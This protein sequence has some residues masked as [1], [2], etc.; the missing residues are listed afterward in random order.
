V[1]DFE[2][3]LRLTA[4]GR[5]VVTT[6]REVSRELDRYGDTA[7]RTGRQAEQAG[8]RS[9]RMGDGLSRAGRDARVARGELGGLTRELGRLQTLAGGIAGI[10]LVAGLGTG[11]RATT[12]EALSYGQALAEV[13]TLIEGTREEM[14]LLERATREQAAAFGSTPTAQANALYQIISAGASDAREAILLLEAANRLAI[15]GVTDVRTAADGLTTIL[16]AYGREADAA[17]DISDVLF[18]AMRAGKTTI[19]ELATEFGT[20][21]SLAAQTEVELEELLAAVAALTLGGIDTNIAMTGLRQVLASVVKPSSEAR[22]EAERLGIEFTTAAL[23]TQGLAGFIEQLVEATGGSEASLSLL[24]GGVEALVPILALAGAQGDDFARILDDMSGRAGATEDAFDKMTEALAVRQTKAIA[25]IREEFLDLAGVLN[26]QFVEGLEATAENLDALTAAG[27]VA[28]ALLAGRFTASLSI[29]ALTAF[30][31][32]NR[33]AVAGVV[34]LGRVAP[35]TAAGLVSLGTAA[36]VARG[37]LALLGGPVGIAASAALG[38]YLFRD[39]IFEAIHATDDQASSLGDLND[40]IERAR[41]LSAEAAEASLRQAYASTAAAIARRE[42]AR[43]ELQLARSRA[44]AERR[45]AGPGGFLGTTAAGVSAGTEAAALEG[46]LAQLDRTLA[47]NAREIEHLQLR[48]LQLAAGTE[49]AAERTEKLGATQGEAADDAEEFARRLA[50]VVG[51]LD[52]AAARAAEYTESVLVLA[53]AHQRG[54]ISGERLADL[55]ARLNAEIYPTAESFLAAVN[56]ELEE[57]ARLLDLSTRERE[58]ELEVRRR[59]LEAQAAGIALSDREIAQLRA[60]IRSTRDAEA[61]AERRAEVERRAADEV[62]DIW[63]QA[64]RRVQET[65]ADAIVDALDGQLDDVEDIADRFVDIWKRAYAEA[66]A[67]RVFDGGE[68]GVAGLSA[69][70][71]QRGPG[72]TPSVELAGIGS[73]DTALGGLTR[74]LDN[75]GTNLGFAAPQPQVGPPVA[76]PGTTLTQGIGTGFQALGAGAVGFSVGQSIGDLLGLGTRGANTLGGAAG[77]AAAGA[78]IGSVVPGIGTAIGAVVGGILGGLGGILGG[79]GGQNPFVEADVTGTGGAVRKYDG[80]DHT[81][82]IRL[83]DAVNESLSAIADAFGTGISARN[84]G[85]I[86]NSEAGVSFRR[87]GVPHD[88]R[89]LFASPEAA[90]VAAIQEGVRSGVVTG[91]DENARTALT[92]SRAATPEA[93][94]ADLEFVSTYNSLLEAGR[95]TSRFSAEL[96][97]LNST[98]A[99]AISR[100]RELGLET[101]A[102]GDARERALGRVRS[103]FEEETRLAILDLTDPVRAALERQQQEARQFLLDAAA[104]GADLDL[105]RRR[106]RLDREALIAE[107][108]AGTERMAAAFRDDIQTILD[109]LRFGPASGL[110]EQ[111]RLPVLLERFQ[112]VAARARFDETA[113]ADLDQVTRE[114]LDVAGSV[115]ASSADFFAIQRQVESQLEALAAAGLDASGVQ[116]IADQVG[117]IELDPEFQRLLDEIGSE[118][119]SGNAEVVDLLTQ[120]R[121]AQIT[122]API[123]Q[124][125]QPGSFPTFDPRQLRL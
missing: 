10:S 7:E 26:E 107:L 33:S 42:E 105:A 123:S 65:F 73:L 56:A 1:T 46:E 5:A 30:V 60:W 45:R 98:F 4:D 31:A 71:G 68:G 49:K 70:F 3:G 34:L 95:E 21:G 78:T 41:D 24:F 44:A 85:V 89:T 9:Q 92:N 48:L 96:R 8:R 29:G 117:Q 39:S 101:D 38:I 91:L 32:A 102:L 125:G 28:A 94:I 59:V 51:Q 93:L 75:F 27:T 54:A 67:A 113:R 55:V 15:G 121:D 25:D 111:E 2:V 104:V 13:S 72:A 52:P 90:V 53:E 58:V 35:V 99:D 76:N 86:G 61:A 88:S 69:L 12:R 87:A 57:E 79:S 20:V 80:A 66:F 50:R 115:F 17:G 22:E 16:N 103:E 114:L 64:R 109:D 6:S 82:A 112:D 116:A 108:T 118:I 36:T 84:F 119:A 40:R 83:R 120:I 124:P 47:G 18:T 100:A 97:D 110:A 62:A 63:Q 23:R 14:A 77:G 122:G 106:V 11:L 74:A 81:V 37:A 19:G 43:A